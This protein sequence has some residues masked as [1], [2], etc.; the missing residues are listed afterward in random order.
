M[1]AINPDAAKIPVLRKDSV[2][3]KELCGNVLLTLASSDL[4]SRVCVPYRGRVV[5]H[6]EASLELDA[7]FRELSQYAPVAYHKIDA[8]GSVRRVNQTEYRRLGVPQALRAIA[9]TCAPGWRR[10]LA[11]NR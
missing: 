11:R 3:T 6:V 5:P 4:R 1:K 9:E 7:P 10:R 2:R 8:T